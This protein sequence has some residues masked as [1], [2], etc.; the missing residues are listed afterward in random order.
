MKS[1]VGMKDSYGS[2]A[3]VIRYLEDLLLKISAKYGFNEIKTPIVEYADVFLRSLGESSD[4]V[5]KEMFCF[6]DKN[7]DMLTLR[8]ENTAGIVRAIFSEG[9]LQDLPLKLSY[10]GPMFRYET[11]QKGRYR[12]F[13][14]VG[15]E[16]L[17]I[18]NPQID[19]EV[20][21]LAWEYIAELKLNNDCVLEINSL[22]DAASRENFKIALTSYLSDKKSQ[23]S[24]ESQ[25]RYD[26]NILRILDSKD[27]NDQLVLK[28]APK[29]SQFLSETSRLRFDK[30]K[31]ILTELNIPFI[32]NE[33]L[34]RGLDYYSELVFEVTTNKIG[35]QSTVLA[36]GRYNDLAKQ[37]GGVDFSGI[38]FAAGAER[39]SLMIDESQFKNK[40]VDVAVIS[41]NDDQS[42]FYSM[43][44]AQQIRAKGYTVELPYNESLNKKMKKAN[45]MNATCAV[46]IGENETK[47]Q[48]L[49]VK[50]LA[51]G[52]QESLSLDDFLEKISN[53]ELS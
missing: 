9:L 48:Q 53:Q 43:K 49:T 25:N 41:F 12:Q 7:G 24:V 44:L 27:E 36:G 45:S 5:S 17:G 10:S 21:A 3:K 29:L 33:Q 38:G 32:V 4:I 51:S 35:S 39:L 52:L 22:G 6:N 34:V 31:A 20:V 26:R 30:T 40:K 13:T 23:L 8:P 11:P 2:S 42:I 37:M 18:N 1:V 14:Q 28:N 16:V 47:T 46:I 50:W 15:V 19:A